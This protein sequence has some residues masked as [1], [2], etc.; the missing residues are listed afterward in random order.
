MIF[1][2]C[3]QVGY[4]DIANR[5]LTVGSE[6]RAEKIAEHLDASP[7]PKTITSGR[8]FTTI[9]GYYNG[10]NVSI[11]A[12]GMVSAPPQYFAQKCLL[13]TFSFMWYRAHQ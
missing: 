3:T 1:L 7:A 9:T 2:P 11:V 6:H 10:V 13:L 4:G 8:G 5:V 12:I